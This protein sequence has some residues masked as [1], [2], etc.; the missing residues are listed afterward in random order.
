MGWTPEFAIKEKD[1]T[2]KLKIELFKTKLINENKYDENDYISP[3]EFDDYEVLN[4]FGTKIVKIFKSEGTTLSIQI[5]S[6]L[7]KN[8]IEHIILNGEVSCGCKFE[9]TYKDLEDLL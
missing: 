9:V 3:Y 4:V 1:F 8:K 5:H 6:V 7:E 2:D